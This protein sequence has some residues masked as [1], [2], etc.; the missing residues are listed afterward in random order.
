MAILA[1]AFS[2][3]VGTTFKLPSTLL[4]QRW[5]DFIVV[6]AIALK[7]IESFSDDIVFDV[8]PQFGACACTLSM[9]AQT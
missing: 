6:L 3:V 8:R 4:L 7:R 5:R 1:E 2:G 9:A